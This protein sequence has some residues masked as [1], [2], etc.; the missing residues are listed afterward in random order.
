M[1]SINEIL[2]ESI[3]DDDAIDKKE[4]AADLAMRIKSVNE[5]FRKGGNAAMQYILK[6]TPEQI[7]SVDENGD[8]VVKWPMNVDFGIP[9]IPD[10]KIVPEAGMGKDGI[11]GIHVCHSGKSTHSLKE[12]TEWMG[13]WMDEHIIWGISRC[14]F[15]IAPDSKDKKFEIDPA[16]MKD[17]VDK[18]SKLTI[19]IRKPNMQVD[20]PMF[21]NV[22]TIEMA[23]PKSFDY[24]IM[25]PMNV[26]NISIKKRF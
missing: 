9:D 4:S 8:T 2:S 20:L 24:P 19:W 23:L 22:D 5:F 14:I 16:M 21:W 25:V 26:K 6:Q 7:V 1:K 17:F 3:L 11:I 13:K 15:E 18:K 12:I 10:F